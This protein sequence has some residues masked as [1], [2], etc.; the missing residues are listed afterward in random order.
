[1]E[2]SV[3]ADSIVYCDTSLV[4]DYM[5][6]TGR[7]PESAMRNPF[8]ESEFNRKQR[9][10]WETLF[11]ND[12]RYQFAVKLRS[13]VGWNFPKSRMVI[14]PF[15][16]LELD[17]WFAEEVFKRHA[18]EGTHVKA[19]QTHNRKQIGEFIQQVVRDAKGADD[20][21]AAQLWG[22]MA[23]GARGEYL[24]GI[25]IKPVDKL[26]FDSGVFSKVSLLSHMQL[27]MADIV[28]LLA[29]EALKCS[30][31]ASTDSDFNRLRAEIEASFKFK[32][33]FKDEIF[34]VVKAGK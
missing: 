11:R 17:E 8:P 33:L 31:F 19:I 23:S 21:F 6:A 7:E 9:S 15:V 32:I 34:S 29:A 4:I 30:H 14:S 5:L 1:M 3:K 2:K 20:S 16:L 12:K 27:G 26:R 13:L 28:H 18:L 24:A 10:Y 22:E 25:M